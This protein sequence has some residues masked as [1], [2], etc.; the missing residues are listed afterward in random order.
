MGWSWSWNPAWTPCPLGVHDG[1]MES[2]GRV[3]SRHNA[4]VPSSLGS[5][6]GRPR[7]GPPR[8]SARWPAPGV[9]H[10]GRRVL[11]AARGSE[12]CSA[13]CRAGRTR[14]SGGCGSPGSTTSPRGARHRR[15]AGGRAASTGCVPGDEREAADIEVA[16]LAS[17]GRSGD[18][19]RRAGHLEDLHGLLLALERE[20][21][22]ALGP[23]RAPSASSWVYEPT[24]TIPGLATEDSR[25]L[26]MFTVSPSTVYSFL[27]T[28]PISPA[29]ALPLLIPMRIRR[30]GA[31]PC[32]RR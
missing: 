11:P 22:E 18:A 32:A 5:W 4:R 30:C 2:S 19:A 24:T 25:R 1:E 6:A 31:L 29:T 21:T 15:R 26:A 28:L 8:A 13:G 10:L 7:R 12:P 14:G 17:P 9:R 23:R 20:G 3:L 16:Y 27:F